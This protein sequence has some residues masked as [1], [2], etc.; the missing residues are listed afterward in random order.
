MIDKALS[1][2]AIASILLATGCSNAPQ[3]DVHSAPRD[4]QTW[5]NIDLSGFDQAQ[6]LAHL[7]RLAGEATNAAATGQSIEFHHLEVAITPTLEALE[8]KADGKPKA[9]ETLALIKDLA[10]KLH[11]A[12]HD[13]NVSIGVKLS[14]KITELSARLATEL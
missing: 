7:N 6:L 5:E 10:V 8:T 4:T 1:F 11:I 13:G 3:D 14:A 9:L 12:G 2:A